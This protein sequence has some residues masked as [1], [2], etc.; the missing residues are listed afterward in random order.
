VLSLRVDGSALDA[1]KPIGRH[2]TTPA[3]KAARV[4][5]KPGSAQSD[6]YVQMSGTSVSTAMVAGVAAL[7]LA[8]HR[9]YTPTK[10]KGA[11]VGSTYGIVGSVSRG[12]DAVRALDATTPGVNGRLVPSTLLMTMLAKSGVV[13]WERGVT[14]EKGVSWEAVTWEAVTWEAV[15]WEL[16]SWERAVTWEGVVWET[17]SGKSVMRDDASATQLAGADASR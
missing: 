15:T 13:G 11:I 3:L 4:A 12:V 5:P 10:T 6:Q 8:Y 14:W 7:V 2:A 17:V 16:V 9:D 1:A